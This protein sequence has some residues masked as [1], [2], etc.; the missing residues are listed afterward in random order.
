MLTESLRKFVSAIQSHVRDTHS[1][2][3]IAEERSF[4]FLLTTEEH[5]DKFG[6]LVWDS[7]RPH[8]PNVRVIVPSYI[9]GDTDETWGNNTWMSWV[10]PF[11]SAQHALYDAT[12][13]MRNVAQA[14]VLDAIKSADLFP[15]GGECDAPHSVV[16]IGESGD[17]LQDTLTFND[18]RG[19][20]ANLLTNDQSSVVALCK[21]FND[22]RH[23]TL[24]K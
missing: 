9:T 11:P 18:S 12:C 5:N 2:R 21:A 7:T 16:A 14:E 10:S 17:S 15:S 6:V 22:V 24:A 23:A 8:A 1:T 3:V 20:V 4:G 19:G 13:T